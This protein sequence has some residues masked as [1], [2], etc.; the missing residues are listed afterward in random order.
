[1]LEFDDSPEGGSC[2]YIA[3]KGEGMRGFLLS[4]NEDKTEGVV[5]SFQNSCE[6]DVKFGKLY[7]IIEF[8]PSKYPMQHKEVRSIPQN[9]TILNLREVEQV[10]DIEVSS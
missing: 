7:L 6:G 5:L 9:H 8:D 4:T 1:M 3:T 10:N 2:K